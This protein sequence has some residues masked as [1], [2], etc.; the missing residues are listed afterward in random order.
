MQPSPS[1]M[2]PSLDIIL[3]CYNPEKGWTGR[4]IAAWEKLPE[5]LGKTPD[6]LILVNDG[7]TKGLDL[8][9]IKLLQAHI[10]QLRYIESSPNRGKGHALRLGVEASTA[11]AIIFTDIDFPYEEES[12]AD[13]AQVLFE[14][15]ADVVPGVRD[16]AYYERVPADRKRISHFLRWMLRT[17]LRLKTTDTQCG[18]K[19]FNRKGREVF[20]QTTINR[21]L[22]DLE[23]IF[24]SS[25]AKG[26]RLKAVP[27]TLKPGIQFSHVSMKVLLREGINFGRVFLRALTT[28]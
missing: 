13:I 23:F 16:D 14:G 28:P 17:F 11:E 4:V 6:T 27:V 9:D 26:I 1:I 10:P 7:S 20:L 3:P 24:L 25:R 8:E 18:L 15:E 12:L 22:F 19:G 2:L 5:L 21:F